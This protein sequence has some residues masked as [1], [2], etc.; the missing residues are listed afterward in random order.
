[1]LKSIQVLRRKKQ[2][3][4]KTYSICHWNVNIITA[5]GYTKVSLKAYITAHKMDITCLSEAYL[6][7]SI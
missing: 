6:E 4:K 5:Y 7:S 3:N 1:M 2:T